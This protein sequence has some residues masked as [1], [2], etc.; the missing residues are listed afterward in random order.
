MSRS[1]ETAAM[2]MYEMGWSIAMPFL[3]VNH[4]LVEG[5]DQ[6]CLKIPLPRADLWIQGASVGE[7]FLTRTILT[8]WTPASRLK[9]L[10]T[11][12]TP[13]GMDILTRKGREKKIKT[14]QVTASFAYFPF[15]K[16][17]LM[18]K[19]VSSVSPRLMVLL[20]T[21]LW[22]GLLDALT[23][24]GSKILIIN[25]RI[26]PESLNKYMLWRS[27]WKNRAP[28]RILAV[29]KEDAKRF[30]ILFEEKR[31]FVMSNI[32]FDQISPASTGSAV[33][34]KIKKIIPKNA[35]FA[36]LASIRQEEEPLVEKMIAKILAEKPETIIGLFPRHMYRL[37][38]W[39]R[40]LT[41]MA[42]SWKLRSEH[43]APAR[44]GSVIL[45][46]TVGELVASYKM[47]KTAFVGGSLAPLGGQNF[48]EP[49][50]C[51]VI[52]IIGPSWHNFY[53][54]GREIMEKRLVK[55]AKDW[56]TAA[57][58]MIDSLQMNIPRE[59]VHSKA[60]AYIHKRQGGTAQAG[61]AINELLAQF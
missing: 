61:R 35:P 31:V 6:R 38:Y 11:T 30:A 44:N 19:A 17:S 28:D 48:L 36:A 18:K 7:S 51:G 4:R 25:G 49:L 33:S 10:A 41:Q 27:F 46:D 50:T 54:V 53:W 8:H 47:A 39:K 24:A 23:K 26:N 57:T 32:K 29:S 2:A 56:E 15:D 58:M 34:E 13:Q 1:M 9:V 55:I 16:P 22:P 37:E 14:D 20:E 5:L 21:E 40:I 52:P 12:N 45:W 60:M 42:V 59:T 43:E 3:S